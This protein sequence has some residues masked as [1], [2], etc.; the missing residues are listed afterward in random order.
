MRNLKQDK[1][2]RFVLT[3]TLKS[4]IMHLPCVKKN[5]ARPK[6]DLIFFLK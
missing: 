4:T 1:I 6:P 2:A 3:G 5:K